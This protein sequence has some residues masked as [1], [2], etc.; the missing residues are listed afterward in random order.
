MT[1]NRLKY[2]KILSIDA[3]RG[4]GECRFCRTCVTLRIQRK[5]AQPSWKMLP[6]LVLNHDSAK[7]SNRKLGGRN[8]E[9]AMTNGVAQHNAKGGFSA[10]VCAR[11]AS[12]PRHSL[13]SSQALLLLLSCP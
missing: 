1:N 4:G 5:T 6:L 9:P 12:L 10:R 7:L 11:I 3:A 8:G 13:G 2:L